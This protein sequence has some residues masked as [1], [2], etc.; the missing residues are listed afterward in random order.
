MANTQNDN[1][2]VRQYE[3]VKCSLAAE[4][5]VA[6]EHQGIITFA[7]AVTNGQSTLP[8]T[9]VDISRGGIGLRSKVFLPKQSRLTVRIS[10]PASPAGGKSISLSC[11]CKVMRVIMIDRTPMYE[12]GTSFVDPSPADLQIIGDL[13]KRVSEQ[14]IAA[15][16]VTRV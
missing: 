9:L 11:Q 2:V 4:L 12:L 13:L 7:A 16:G 5:T 15:G 8:V 3:R 1:L 10:D 6:T 14:A